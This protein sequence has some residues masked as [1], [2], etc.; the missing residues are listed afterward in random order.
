MRPRLAGSAYRPVET[1]HYILET[2]ASLIRTKV[3]QTTKTVFTIDCEL[4]CRIQSYCHH[5]HFTTTVLMLLIK[6]EGNMKLK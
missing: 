1:L 5:S 3:F 4:Y 6:S 2:L